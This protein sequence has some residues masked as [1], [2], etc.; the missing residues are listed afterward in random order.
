MSKLPAGPVKA[1]S[2]SSGSKKVAEA[3]PASTGLPFGLRRNHLMGIAALVALVIS[4]FVF[5]GL[6]GA[7][8]D[9]PTAVAGKKGK[10]Q[11]KGNAKTGRGGRGLCQLVKCTDEQKAAVKPVL[12]SYKQ[13]V[14]ADE[15]GLR[16]AYAAVA[17]AFTDEE[18]D[19]AS[20]DEAYATV[21]EHQDA[22]DR[23]ARKALG[24]V[25]EILTPQQRET[26]AKQV[27]RDGP[28]SLFE[29][30]GRGDRPRRVQRRRGKRGAA[31]AGDDPRARMRQLEQSGRKFNPAVGERD[32]DREEEDEEA[33]EAEAPT[34][35][36]A[37]I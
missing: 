33:D 20:L 34:R 13:A 21:G 9:D 29:R 32:S 23:E 2:A 1:S 24:A 18:L 31:A 37:P 22:I 5:R 26:V 11:G 27:A 12:Q 3:A 19:E 25:H 16:E 35:T 17:A 4:V 30:G 10:R 8:E 7:D 6:F 36:S 14:V 15:K 28:A